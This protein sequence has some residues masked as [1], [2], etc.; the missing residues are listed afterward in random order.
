MDPGVSILLLDEAGRDR[1][2]S[3]D[4]KLSSDSQR[5]ADLE[6]IRKFRSNT[7]RGCAGLKKRVGRGLLVEA[8][9]RP[10]NLL[11]YERRSG[12]SSG[13]NQRGKPQTRKIR[14][15]DERQGRCH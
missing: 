5:E 8:Q 14:R 12:P 13:G 4:S 6:R 11:T 3:E 9:T 1:C 7:N 10:T 15:E 2:P